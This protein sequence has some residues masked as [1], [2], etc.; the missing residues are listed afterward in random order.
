MMTK[1]WNGGVE[2]IR[3]VVFDVG[4]VLADFRYRDYMRDLGFP[5]ETVEFLARNMVETDY[6]AEL[7]LGRHTIADA[8][9]TFTGRYPALAGEIRAF[10]EN[11]RHIVAEYDYAQPLI[12]RLKEKGYGVYLLSNYPVET[13]EMHWPTF[14]FLPETDG[15]IISGYEKLAKPDPAI[16]RLLE[17]RFGLDLGT[18]VFIDDNPANVKAARAVGMEAVRFTGLPALEEALKDLGV[19]L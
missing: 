3:C 10:W 18:C 12:H 5:E 14:R 13:A 19:T 1:T 15:R 8:V 17:S 2:M 16:Y 7:D 11:I 4:N 6:W 9:E